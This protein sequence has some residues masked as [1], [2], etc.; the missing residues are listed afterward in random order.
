M[1]ECFMYASLDRKEFFMIDA[2]GGATKTPG[3]GRNLGSR[4]LGL[5]LRQRGA[6]IPEPAGICSWAGTR[7]AVVG[8]YGKPN[9]LGVTTAT[10]SD[11][12]RNLFTLAKETFRNTASTVAVMLFE[13]DGSAEL[14]EVART[15]ER[16]F[17]MLAE[18]AIV[19]RV[20]TIETVMGQCFESDWKK[21]YAEKRKRSLLEI[22]HP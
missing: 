2:L 6:D 5:L 12:K 14:V 15:N 16:V 9:V 20:K 3:I 1:G 21:T 22:P 7:V 8:E 13:H 17:L 18:L 4:G 11:P 19:Y 10:A